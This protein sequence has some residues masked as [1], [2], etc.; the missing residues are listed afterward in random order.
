MLTPTTDP[1]PRRL[2]RPGLWIAA[3]GLAVAGAVL[4]WLVHPAWAA[5]AVL[6]GLA[7]ILVPDPAP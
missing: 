1:A 2:A 7:L 6:G 4:G 3:G 5:L